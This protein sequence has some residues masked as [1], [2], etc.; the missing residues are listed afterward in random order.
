MKAIVYHGNR[1]I[2]YEESYPEP[3]ITHESEVKIKIDYCGI[4]G[5]DLH[6]YIDGPIFFEDKR[7]KISGLPNIQCMGHEFSGVVVE[8]GSNVDNVK[9]GD[10][11]VVE[12]TGTCLE[13]YRFPNSPNFKEDL[14]CSCR[15]GHINTCDNTG[16]IGLG[17]TDG[18]FSEYCVVGKDYVLP[19]PASFLSPKV[20]ALIEP[21]SVAWHAVRISGFKAGQLALILGGGPI[22]LATIIALKAHGAGK[23]IISEPAEGRRVLAQNLGAL[24]YNPKDFKDSSDLVKALMQETEGSFG[25]N[26]SYECSGFPVSFEVA[27]KAL[28]AHG[29]LTNVAV[30]HQLVDI[31]PM[32]FTLKEKNITGSMAHELADFKQIIQAFENGLIS[33]KE[34]E[35]LIT[36]VVP[37]KEGIEKGFDELLNH[38]EKH[39]KILL[40]P[41]DI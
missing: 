31:N 9:V 23:I 24:S 32:A 20:A 29:T 12:P 41:K 7:N 15:E 37:L 35:S 8:I 16:Y 10:N 27:H 17:F 3:K 38:R 14:C 5:S 33:P 40:T 4:C 22:G 1:D 13:R 19:Y 6:E 36:G 21:L 30:W 18:G 28:R 34:V 26:N 39:I 11:V 2:R 25:F